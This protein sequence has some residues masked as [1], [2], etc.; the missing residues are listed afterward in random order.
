MKIL[1]V[2]GSSRESSHTLKFIHFLMDKLKYHECEI[3]SELRDLK[4]F[5]EGIFFGVSE[6]KWRSHV[7]WA[8]CIIIVTPEYLKNIPAAIKNGLEWLSKNGEMQQKKTLSIIYT[9]EYPRG[10][11]AQISLNNSLKGIK[12]HLIATELIHYTDI[13]FDSEG[14]CIKGS[15][16]ELFDIIVE[17]LKN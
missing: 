12:A 17:I 5:Y 8:D 9:P 16:H 13:M 7:L 15:N 2:S 3:A 14:T 10:K 6:E 4:L 11:D 1:F